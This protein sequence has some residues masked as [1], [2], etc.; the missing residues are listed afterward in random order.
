MH[1][2]THKKLTKYAQ[3]YASKPKYS[4]N[5]AAKIQ[6]LPRFLIFLN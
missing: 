6:F 1:Y 2:N 5:Y 4:R 3:K